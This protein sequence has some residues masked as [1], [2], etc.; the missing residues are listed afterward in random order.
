M[1][2]HAHSGMS[3]H[4]VCEC[5]SPLSTFEDGSPGCG[6]TRVAINKIL[7]FKERHRESTSVSVPL[8]DQNHTQVPH[9][10]LPSCPAV[11]PQD[12]GQE[13]RSQTNH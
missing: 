6:M 5:Q 2:K 3:L 10:L 7:R 11:S 13:V 4:T 12:G 1:G 8:R 9:I